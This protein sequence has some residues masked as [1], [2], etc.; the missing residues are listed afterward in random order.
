MQQEDSPE[1]ASMISTVPNSFLQLADIM[2][3]NAAHPM[4]EDAFLKLAPKLLVKNHRCCFRVYFAWG[5]P[6]IMYYC[7]AYKLDLYS[8]RRHHTRQEPSRCC[9][10]SHGDEFMPGNFSN[11]AQFQFMEKEVSSWNRN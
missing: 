8:I 6:L 3:E 1:S 9:I 11:P 2:V 7:T 4:L 10:I 5:E